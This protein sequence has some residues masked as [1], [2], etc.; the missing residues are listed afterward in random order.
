VLSTLHTN[1]APGA[2]SRL[3]EMGIEPFLTA[4]AID[5]VISQ[6]LARVLCTNCKERV[7]LSANALR[8][9]GFEIAYD[10]EAYE[11]RGCPRCKYT[12]YRGRVGLYEAMT[13]SDQLRELAIERASA[14][15][16]R[17]VAVEQGMQMLQYD[18]FAKVQAGITSIEEVARVTG[19]VPPAD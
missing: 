17:R 18:G 4:S 8:N 12:G 1:D 3:T 19:S 15:A 7:L 9:S 13:M 16:I 11:P 6:R 2:I 5:C 10:L 14:D